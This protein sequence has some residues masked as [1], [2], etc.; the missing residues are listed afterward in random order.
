MA[1]EGVVSRNLPVKTGALATISKR[2]QTPSQKAK[3]YLDMPEFRKLDWDKYDR[4]V[5]EA[6]LVGVSGLD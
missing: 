4:H 1:I 2:L 6:I 5:R 3:A